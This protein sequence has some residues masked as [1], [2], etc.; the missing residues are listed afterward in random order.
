MDY[1]V[2]KGKITVINPRDFDIRKT[3]ECGQVFRYKKIDDGYETKVGDWDIDATKFPNGLEPIVDKIHGQGLKAGLW[4]APFAVQF[5]ANLVKE[6]PDWFIRNKRGR[7]VISGI[8]WGG[9]YAIDFEKEEVRA[10]IKALF[11]RVFDEWG[12]DMVKLDF[13]YSAAIQPRNGKTRGQ[14]MCEAMDFLISPATVI[15]IPAFPILPLDALK[16]K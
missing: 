5:G 15:C 2:E 11:D 4:L 16:R 12:F 3:L 10:H 13:L 8:A 1:I 7:K 6:H 14:S 9:F